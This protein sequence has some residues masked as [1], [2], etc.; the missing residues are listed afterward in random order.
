LIVKFLL[1]AAMA[2][3][4][5]APSSVFAANQ[6]WSKTGAV[7]GNWRAIIF[8]RV[9]SGSICA[10]VGAFIAQAETPWWQCKLL[11]GGIMQCD[12]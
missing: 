4:V 2:F 7:N 1:A 10:H 9:I 6:T 12:D 3:F 8:P 11:R 5:L